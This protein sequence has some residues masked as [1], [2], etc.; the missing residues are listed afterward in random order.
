M[1]I[2]FYGKSLTSWPYIVIIS[3]AKKKKKQELV[4]TLASDEEEEKKV[5]DATKYMNKYGIDK[6]KVSNA[7]LI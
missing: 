4:L 7:Q 6:M 1:V 3:I 2:L 5:S